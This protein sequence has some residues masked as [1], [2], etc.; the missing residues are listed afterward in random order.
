MPTGAS[1]GYVLTSD[2]TGA[3]S[4]QPGGGTGDITSVDAGDG[5]SGGGASGGVSLAVNTGT[6]LEISEDDVQ[7]TGPYQD[8]SAYVGVFAPTSHDHD[9]AYI[10]DEAGEIDSAADFGLTTAPHI[11]NLNA[12]LLDGFDSTQIAAANHD[13]DATYVNE[14]QADAVTGDMVVPDIVSSVDG[15]SNDAGNIDLIEGANVTITPDDGANT[16]TIAAAGGGG[17]LDDAYDFGGPGAGGTV[18]VDAGGVVL[19]AT[20]NGTGNPALII[21]GDE[22]YEPA[23]EIA[24]TE[25]GYE[26]WQLNVQGSGQFGITRNQAFTP[27]RIDSSSFNNALVLSSGG[28]GVGWPWPTE[29]LHVEGAVRLGTTTNSNAGTIRWTGSDFEGYDGAAWQSLTPSAGGGNTLDG[30]YDEGGPG[31]GRT[32]DV[33]SGSVILDAT[34]NGSNPGLLIRGDDGYEPGIRLV[35]DSTHTYSL[36]NS[37][38]E[39]MIAKAFTPSGTPFRITPDATGSLAIAAG[40]VGLGTVAPNEMLQVIGAINLGNTTNSNAGSIRWTGADFEGYDGAAW[41]SLTTSAGGIGGSGTASYFPLFT[42]TNTIGNS[43]MYYDGLSIVM[44]FARG[45]RDREEAK[46]GARSSRSRGVVGLGAWAEDYTTIFGSVTQTTPDSLGSTGVSGYR[47]RTVESPGVGYGA[48]ENNN[49]VNGLNYWGDSYTFGVAG[50]CWNDLTRTGAVLGAQWEGDYWGALGYKDENSDTWGVYTPNDAYVGGTLSVDEMDAGG[51]LSFVNAQD[52]IA[53]HVQETETFNGPNGLGAVYGVRSD[54]GTNPGNGYAYGNANAALS[55][56]NE[57]GSSYTFGVTGHNSIDDG[58]RTG[59]VLGA[60]DDGYPWG[61]LAYT[62]ENAAQWGIYTPDDAHVGGQLTLPQG[63]SSGKVLTSDADGVASW[64][65]SHT[66]DTHN[67]GSTTTIGTTT[68]QY[69]EAEVN[70]SATRSGLIV[71]TSNVWVK[72]D[73]TS[74][75][76]DIVEVN[77]STS[78]TSAGDVYTRV[79]WEVPAGAPS[80]SAIDRTLTVVSAF[81]VSSGGFYDYYLVGRMSSG[82][83]PEDRFWFAQT[84]AVYYPGA[85]VREEPPDPELIEKLKLM[86]EYE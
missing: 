52:E 10:N 25:T 36:Y 20:A 80:D 83:D 51:T 6:G 24:N 41:Q 31:V 55:G 37:G 61:A 8:G 78:P 70:I 43:I 15:V 57:T 35:W 12:D 58:V 76:A 29:M 77:H 47:T 54:G 40:G 56:M 38:G 14:G 22:L 71:V 33:D 66:Y 32:I 21:Q 67:E 85:V 30:A 28:V 5:L 26:A 53:L 1:A 2:A 27:F 79:V 81:P 84:S 11:A 18:T 86:G 64:E 44:P 17:T 48:W 73:H 13:H 9:A 4:W 16:I 3:A 7:L 46:A 42:D 63:H 60:D 59:G 50:H 74:G 39:F 69:D 75:T 49:G 23:I 68:T 45:A 62:D 72:L 65:W 82:Q 19:D 34:E